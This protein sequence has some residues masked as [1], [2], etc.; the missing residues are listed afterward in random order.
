MKIL[1]TGVNATQAKKVNSRLG[2]INGIYAVMEGLQECGHEVT[3][4]PIVPGE[5]LDEFDKIIVYLSPL[6]GFSSGFFLGAMWAISRAAHGKLIL[7]LD[8]WQSHKI[9]DSFKGFLKHADKNWVKTI[10]HQVAEWAPYRKAITKIIDLMANENWYSPLMAPTFYG[11][12]DLTDLGVP[13]TGAQF[14]FDP[15]GYFSNR[16]DTVPEKKKELKWVYCSLTNRNKWLDRT[17]LAWRIAA[18]GHGGSG[19]LR[20]PEIQ[21]VNQEYASAMGVLSPPTGHKSGLWWRS[22]YQFAIEAG[23]ILAGDSKETRF[24]GN[25]YEHT[26]Y[27][28]EEMS[29]LEL[30]K[31]TDLQ[32]S[33]YLGKRWSR[34]MLFRELAEFIKK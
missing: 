11:K 24:C 12:G 32:A 10:W 18:F 15:S 14:C 20:V 31:T 5:S 6:G 30:K 13:S 26:P 29:S 17:A 23:A 22:R 8:D 2:L 19:Q 27:E 33:T 4:R 16:Y 1:I 9:V 28:I 21:L 7:A 34:S 3:Q 25:G